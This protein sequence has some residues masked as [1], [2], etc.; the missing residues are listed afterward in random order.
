MV[1]WGMIMEMTIILIPLSII[2]A[3][4]PMILY[5]LTVWLLDWF[6][7]EPI[8]LLGGTFLW[9]GLGGV[10]IALILQVGISPALSTL[11]EPSMV[12]Q[13]SAAVIAPLTEEPG[14]ALLLL[15]I[16]QSRHFD[17]A[18]DGFVYGAAAGLGFGM[19]ENFKYFMEGALGMDPISWMMMVVVRTLCS[20]VMHALCTSIVGVSI[21]FAKQKGPVYFFG[22]GTVGLLVAMGIHGLWNGILVIERLPISEDQRLLLD[23]GILAIEVFLGLCLFFGLLIAERR[24]IRRFLLEEVKNGTLSHDMIDKTL[25]LFERIQGSSWLPN[26]APKRYTLNLITTLGLRLS[27]LEKS[28]GPS[29]KFF[30]REVRRIRE[31]LASI[32]QSHHV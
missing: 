11:F 14:K 20:A 28:N 18:S 10:G 23:V 21:G 4:I 2:A 13:V 6:D 25:S 16:Y 7:R 17:N 8:W 12:E 1:T 15:L 3:V 5:L 26:V 9:G 32:F 31:E 22:L 24:N 29:R 19:T 30:D 27:Q